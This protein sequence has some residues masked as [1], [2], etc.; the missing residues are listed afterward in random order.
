MLT[1]LPNEILLIRAFFSYLSSWADKVRFESSSTMVPGGHLKS[2]VLYQHLFLTENKDMAL[3]L[4][5]ST[6]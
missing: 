6:E 4:S 5:S 3:I 2:E 1:E